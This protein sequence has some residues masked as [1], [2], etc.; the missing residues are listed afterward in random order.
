[1]PPSLLEAAS[2]PAA[3]APLS[4]PLVELT[5]EELLPEELAPEELLPEELLPEE[6]LPEEGPFE[7]P[8]L[9]SEEPL[10]AESPLP[11][12]LVWPKFEL[13]LP[14]AT[15]KLIP[16]TAAPNDNEKNARVE[17][18]VLRLQTGDIVSAPRCS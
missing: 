13:P 8:P 15:A 16:P 1:M 2:G 10:L 3:T 6:L 7:E 4:L 11:P 17:V 18:E 12:L 9:P 14:Q 5:P